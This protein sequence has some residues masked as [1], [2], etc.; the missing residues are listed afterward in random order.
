MQMLT[1]RE[2]LRSH[3]AWQLMMKHPMF[4]AMEHRR[5]LEGL[6]QRSRNDFVPLTLLEARP[7]DDIGSED[8]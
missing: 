7:E 4:M 1:G 8:E 3:Y 6:A 5:E 2:A